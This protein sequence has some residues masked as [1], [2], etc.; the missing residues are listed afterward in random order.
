MQS[1]KNKCVSVTS[2]LI[3]EHFVMKSCQDVKKKK[4]NLLRGMERRE[5][6]NSGIF[7]LTLSYSRNFEI[8]WNSWFLHREYDF[9]PDRSLEFSLRKLLPAHLWAL[10]CF[11]KRLQNHRVQLWLQKSPLQFQCG[12][13]LITL[14]QRT[15]ISGSSE[16]HA[17][18]CQ[19]HVIFSFSWG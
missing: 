12:Q 11:H 19:I 8:L 9:F 4:K 15:F 1:L 5:L 10:S 18:P 6:A 16:T 2:Q 14:T 7:L 13:V 17:L 3:P